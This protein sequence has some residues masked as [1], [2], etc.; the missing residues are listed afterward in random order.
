MTLPRSARNLSHLPP[1]ML[2]RASALCG[3]GEILIFIP[4]RSL[5]GTTGAL[6]F[7]YKAE[8]SRFSE[9]DTPPG[10]SRWARA[11]LAAGSAVVRFAKPPLSGPSFHLGM[12]LFSPILWH[13]GSTGNPVTFPLPY[14]QALAPRGEKGALLCRELTLFI[15]HRENA[16]D[17]QRDSFWC[18]PT[19]NLFAC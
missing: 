12:V 6:A 17:K 8:M 14:H 3:C 11:G 13:G 4:Q 9:A 19:I 7:C 1:G 16:A 15:Y 18:Q 10:K 5:L 2:L